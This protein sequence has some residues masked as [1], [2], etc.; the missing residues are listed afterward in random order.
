MIMPKPTGRRP[1]GTPQGDP[2]VVGV[3]GDAED[4]DPAGGVL[5]QSEDIGAGAIEEVDGEEVR[6]HDCLGLTVPEL[7][8]HVGPSHRGGGGIPAVIRISHTVDGA[9]RMP[10]PASSPWIRR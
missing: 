6:R 3:C 7:R 5:D 8:A 4:P 9:T 10:R 2:R 1:F